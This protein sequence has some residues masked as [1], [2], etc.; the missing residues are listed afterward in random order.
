MRNQLT[1]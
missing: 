1:Y